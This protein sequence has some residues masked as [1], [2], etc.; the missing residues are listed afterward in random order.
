MVAL[1]GGLTVVAI[2]IGG[3]MVLPRLFAQAARTPLDRAAGGCDGLANLFIST[4][5]APM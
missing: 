1:R 3:R 5:P 2:Y 4:Q